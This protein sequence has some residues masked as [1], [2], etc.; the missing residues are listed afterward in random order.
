MHGKRT[1]AVA[2]LV[3]VLTVG[4]LLPVA[5]QEDKVRVLYGTSSMSEAKATKANDITVR[6]DLIEFSVGVDSGGAY[7]MPPGVIVDAGNQKTGDMVATLGFVANNFGEW[8]N[9]TDIGVITETPDEVVVRSKGHWQGHKNVK[10]TTW[11]TLRA[12]ESHI[13]LYT[14][15]ENVG[16]TAREMVTGYGVSMSGMQ[17]YLPGYGDVTSGMYS[18]Q[19]ADTLPLN[20]VGGYNEN[21][22]TYGFY[23]E[24]MTDFTASDTWVDPFK[25][26]NLKPGDKVIEEADFYI[27]EEKD[28]SK[29][30]ATY[31]E[32]NDIPTGTFSTSV[33]DSEGNVVPNPYVNIKQDGENIV[34]VQGDQEGVLELELAKGDYTVD[35][36]L[37]SYSENDPVEFSVKAGETN[38]LTYDE[39]KVPGTVDFS[40]SLE[41][42]GATPAQVLVNSDGKFRETI[43]TGFEGEASMTLPP[44]T[45]T[46]DLVYGDNFTTKEIN[47]EVT[48]DPGEMDTVSATF[49]KI[50]QPNEE[51]YYGSD[52]HH[53]SNILDGTTPPAD[54]VRSFL[55]SDL[56]LTIVTDHNKVAN[57]EKIA[58]LSEE[59]GIPFIPSVEI[60]TQ[61]W[62]HFN[63]YPLDVGKNPIYKGTPDEFF[64]DARDK[65]ATFIQVNHPNTN[66]SYFDRTV[67]QQDDG[68]KLSE[69]YVGSYDGIE[70]NGS[71]D[72][73]DKKT[74][75]ETY[76]FWNKGK[77]YTI[78]ANSDTHNVWQ[79]WGGSGAQRT[80]AYVEGDLTVDKYVKALNEQKAFWT[81]GPL[82]YMEANGE[83]PGSELKK[84][85][86]TIRAALKSTDGLKKAT[87]IK[88]GKAVK[89]FELSGN[90]FVIGYGTQVEG[91]GWFALKVTEQDGDLA[92]TNPVWY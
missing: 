75:Q 24:E 85:T 52:L 54:L 88:N 77:K 46:F 2:L 92:G 59:H 29:P 10:I 53:H 36:G 9:Y 25:V 32:L 7:G 90:Y 1:F 11:Y 62:G 33:K 30:L 83:V 71:W 17:T 8:V 80:Y 15:V 61:S 68:L 16:D 3:T 47:K 5:A 74:L 12:G 69:D 14:T 23:F 82:V 37:K 44:G 31:Y 41:E 58:S 19:S 70:I 28:V 78:V 6:N 13:N 51:N 34:T 72:D 60:T 67:T 76:E 39:V 49:E 42:S 45:Y 65:G 89:T 27:W 57:H 64:Q 81:Y 26:I 4:F 20:W 56:D 38:E 21:K 91:D 55:A 63:A 18:L 86:V 43:Y 87:L 40:T 73:G 35:G 79:S 50:Y 22:G 48:V 66:G 84:D